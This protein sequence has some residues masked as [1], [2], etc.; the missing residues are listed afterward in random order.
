MLTRRRF[1]QTVGVGAAGA[2]ASSWIGA[3]GR[4]NSLWDAFEPTL[5]AIAAGRHLPLEQREPG[6]PGQEG[7]RRGQGRVRTERRDAGPLLERV[8]RARRGARQEVHRQAG[9]HR[10]RLRLDA[11]PALGDARVHRAH[12][13]ARRHDSDLRGMRRLRGHDGQSRSARCRSIATSRW[14][15]I[16]SRT[17]RSGA[18]LVFFCNPNNPMA[19]YVGARATRDFLVAREPHLAGDDDP[20]RRGVLRLRHRPGSRHAHSARRRGPAHHRRA[21][22][23]EGVRHGGPAH[24]LLRRPPGHHPQDGRLGLGVRHEL[25]ERAR[26]AR[27]RSR[28]SSRI[29][30]SSRPSATATRPCATSR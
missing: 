20:R 24:R 28:P 2:Y 23:L 8:G 15:S 19:T 5:Q 7:P 10:A 1:V 30:A 16:G 18:G 14:I 25:A 9:E 22:V 17:R 6:R 12:Q 3:R 21:D 26:D 29:R 11:D 27:R 13:G 4:E